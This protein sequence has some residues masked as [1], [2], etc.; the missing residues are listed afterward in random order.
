[1]IS[2]ATNTKL[3]VVNDRSAVISRLLQRGRKPVNVVER[4]AWS[5]K[6]GE[7][8]MPRWIHRKRIHR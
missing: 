5:E 2:D 4:V 1:M 6:R 7:E 3:M 8:V